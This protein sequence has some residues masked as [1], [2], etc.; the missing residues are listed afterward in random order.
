MKEELKNSNC[1]SPNVGAGILIAVSQVI[2]HSAGGWRKNLQCHE[3][4]TSPAVQSKE[5]KA[6]NHTN[7]TAT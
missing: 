3:R 7:H 2:R 1:L 4:Q 6:S 5:K